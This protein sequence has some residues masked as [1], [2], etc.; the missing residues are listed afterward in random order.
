MTL[1]YTVVRLID[2]RIVTGPSVR[3][4]ILTTLRSKPSVEWTAWRVAKAINALGSTVS[5]QMFKMR[6]AGLIQDTGRKTD[7]G[8]RI[9]SA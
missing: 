7:R 6:K 5:S 4:A 9:Y 8:G 1:K 3:Q 2:K